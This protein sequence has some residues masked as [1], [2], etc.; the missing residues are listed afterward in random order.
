MGRR[1]AI[2][3]SAIAAAL[4]AVALFSLAA[5]RSVVMQAEMAGPA[6]SAMAMAMPMCG[7]GTLHH[8]AVKHGGEQD[9][10]GKTCEFCAAAGHAA[11]CTSAPD[12][13]P[14][15]ALAW[16][17]YPSLH[18]LGPRGPPEFT[19]RSRGPPSPILTV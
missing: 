4:L 2:G 6:S 8:V 14:S 1:S 3:R 5:V 12:I 16:T 15:V 19:A 7:D 11:A 9:K 18:P 17:A 13:A 10:S